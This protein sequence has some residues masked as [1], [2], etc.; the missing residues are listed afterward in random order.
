MR[1]LEFTVHMSEENAGKIHK[2]CYGF[3]SALF[4]YGLF[5]PDNWA[6]LFG[7][8]A[9]PILWA[10]RHVPI[11]RDMATI[12]SNPEFMAGFMGLAVYM[13]WLCFGCFLW[14]GL[15]D[16]SDPETI[17]IAVGKN[18]DDLSF[19]FVFCTMLFCCLFI[20][21][22]Y[23]F[24][25]AVFISTENMTTND[26]LILAIAN[27][28]FLTALVGSLMIGT[29]PWVML[30]MLFGLLGLYYKLFRPW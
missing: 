5:L 30:A 20:L 11:A 23:V 22:S 4:V 18:P 15:V 12:S 6:E 21:G 17:R 10:A 9:R 13:P 19:S 8:A 3:M 7:I 26:A 2:I 25:L 27:N 29:L 16:R 14:Y 28:R 24:P 1:S